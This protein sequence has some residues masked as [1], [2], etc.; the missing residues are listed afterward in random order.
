MSLLAKALCYFADMPP[1]ICADSSPDKIMP[2]KELMEPL[3]GM[4]EDCSSFT[5]V[6]KPYN[7]RQNTEIECREGKVTFVF[8][9]ASRRD[10]EE[11][12]GVG[13]FE[14]GDEAVDRS[15][16]VEVYIRRSD[17]AGGLIIYRLALYK[18]AMELRPFMSAPGSGFLLR[19]E[20]YVALGYNSQ[21]HLRSSLMLYHM[22]A[23]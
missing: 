9:H 2:K 10:R 6:H 3:L 1:Y 18:N 8:R 13:V 11:C 22:A 12:R 20:D 5:I 16:A 4:G 7:S 21:A 19:P 17:I 15:R 14:T 23:D